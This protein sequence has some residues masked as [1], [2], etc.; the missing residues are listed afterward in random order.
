MPN[1]TTLSP[2]RRAVTVLTAIFMLMAFAVPAQ[3]AASDRGRHEQTVAYW[4]PARMANARP[5]DFEFAPDRGFI[6]NARPDNPGKPGGNGGG[7]ARDVTGASWS[8]GGLIGE[9]S[10]K[11]YFEM[12]GAAYV[13]SGAVVTDARTDVSLVLTAAHCVYDETNGAFA[14]RW[15][16]IPNFDAAPTFSCDQTQHGCWTASALVVHSGYA[17]AGGFNSQAT[18]HDFAFAVVGAGG[19]SDESKQLDTTVGSLPISFTSLPNQTRVYAFGYPAVGKYDGKDLAYCA[20]PLFFDPYNSG[21]TY[22]LKCDM[23]GGSSGGPWLSGFSETSGSG[24][25]S[26][27]NS[28]RYSSIAAMHGPKFNEKTEATYS[29]AGSATT[30]NVIV[31]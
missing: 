15:L 12:N 1:F 13:C 3:T 25:L 20:G 22:G 4:T 7:K 18:Q 8:G 31:P 19:K 28:Y 29:A 2:H 14:T 11:V 30:V 26:S 16:F 27:V 6:S 5:R 17:N 24:V 23:T 9:A 10:G 21:L